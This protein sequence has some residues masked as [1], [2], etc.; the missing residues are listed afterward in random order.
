MQAPVGLVGSLTAI[1]AWIAGSGL[2][3]LLGGLALGSVIPLTLIVIYPTNRQLL[4]PAIAQDLDQADLL[5]KRWNRLH[6][7]RTMLS[8]AALVAFLGLLR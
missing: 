2:G 6:A 4:D 3:W 8:M 1:L 7:V 5:L